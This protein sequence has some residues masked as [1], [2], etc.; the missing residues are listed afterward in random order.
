[1]TVAAAL[2]LPTHAAATQQQP[3]NASAM[4]VQWLSPLDGSILAASPLGSA[5]E[6]GAASSSAP[7]TDVTFHL[8]GRLIG[9]AS[10]PPYDCTIDPATL[11]PGTHVLTA[12]GYDA[13]GGS[14]SDTAFVYVPAPGVTPIPVTVQGDSLTAGSA[15]R[16][17]V[18]LGPAFR[19]VSVSM[20]I[21]RTTATG[22]R[23]LRAQP[24]GRVV[25]FALGTN[26]WPSPETYRARL[27]TVLRMVGPGRCLVVPTIWQGGR[28]VSGLNRVLRSLRSRY[29]PQRLQLAG[30]ASAVADGRVQTPDGTHPA[31]G[32]WWVRAQVVESAIRACAAEP[33]ATLSPMSALVDRP[34]HV[35]PEGGRELWAHVL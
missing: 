21:G 12:T 24:L 19:L 6:A 27:L 25:V 31:R 33:S 9:I 28:P 18:D 30:W 26:G 5:C 29:G 23:L 16:M 3:A 7:V 20:H 14:S 32:Q 10:A 34:Q 2:L 15:P 35:R 4:S 22:L 17:A 13:G 11:T 1:M 8:D